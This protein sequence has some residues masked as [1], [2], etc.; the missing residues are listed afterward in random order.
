VDTV[1][2]VDGYERS[3]L[4]FNGTI[5]GPTIIADWGDDVIIHVANNLVLNGTAIHWHGIRQLGTSEYD[6][7]PGVTQCPIAPGDTLTY[8]FHADRK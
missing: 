6:G 3:T 4:S 5:P 7:V 8:K 1:I 2:A